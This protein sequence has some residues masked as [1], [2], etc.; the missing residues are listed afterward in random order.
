[1]ISIGSEIGNSNDVDGSESPKKKG[2]CRGRFQRL[3]ASLGSE[4]NHAS[5][6]DI[7]SLDDQ[8]RG[9]FQTEDGMFELQIV[10]D[11]KKLSISTCVYSFTTEFASLAVM[12][13]ALELN[14]HS[15]RGDRHGF[16]LGID[17]GR[18]TGYKMI[19]M[20]LGITRRISRMSRNDVIYTLS[21]FIE[22]ANNVRSKLE[23]VDDGRLGVDPT[24]FFRL[25][26]PYHPRSLVTTIPVHQGNGKAKKKAG[27]NRQH[28]G[29]RR[30]STIR[31]SRV[32]EKSFEKTSTTM[33]L[34]LSNTA[35]N[36]DG[37]GRRRSNATTDKATAEL[38]RKWQQARHA[39]RKTGIDTAPAS[40]HSQ[41]VRKPSLESEKEQPLKP[42]GV[43][44]EKTPVISNKKRILPISSK[45]GQALPPP[46]QLPNQTKANGKKKKRSSK[47]HGY[48]LGRKS[49]LSSYATDYPQSRFQT[50]DDVTITSTN[51]MYWV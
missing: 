50:D 32:G 19:P 1:M 16:T 13:K 24:P 47:S 25:E 22:I 38:H 46:H 9:N 27:S 33:S 7:L 48:D 45:G 37:S 39:R 10:Q 31:T 29:H 17:P 43:G 12:K 20:I 3:L 18:S 23:E 8:G 14:H 11:A 40:P 35:S 44:M 4:K 2:W 49:G 15:A 6:C 30:N 41:P 26:T 36:F 21:N 34:Q 51:D 5:P 28:N 42:W